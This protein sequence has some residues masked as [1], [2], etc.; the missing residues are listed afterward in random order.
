MHRGADDAHQRLA[1]DWEHQSFALA[2]GV[3]DG[4]YTGLALPGD[5]VAPPATVDSLL[6]VE[7]RCAVEQHEH[8]VNAAPTPEPG[9]ISGPAR[10]PG[11]TPSPGPS[12]GPGAQH[13]SGA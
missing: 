9:P 6:I 13:V 12:S 11:R 2:T 8:E 10:G 1:L 5:S 4:T 7:P 3:D